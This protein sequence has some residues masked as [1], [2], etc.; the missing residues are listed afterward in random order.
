LAIQDVKHRVEIKRLKKE[1]REAGAATRRLQLE[2]ESLIIE[3]GAYTEVRSHRLQI[4]DENS[5]HPK[6]RKVG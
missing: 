1:Y 4:Y 5:P 3:P 6:R 2:E